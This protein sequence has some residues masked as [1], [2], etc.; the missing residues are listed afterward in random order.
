MRGEQISATQT[1]HKGGMRVEPLAA[2]RFFVIFWKK[3]AILMRFGS[4]FARFQSHL[5]EQ[6]F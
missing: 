2:G 5:K 6:S 1:C 3:M 4:R